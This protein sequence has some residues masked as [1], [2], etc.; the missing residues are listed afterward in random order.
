MTNLVLSASSKIP[1]LYEK[2]QTAIAACHSFDE[3]KAIADQAAAI[4]AYHKQIKDDVAMRQFL[5]IVAT[6]RRDF[7]SV[8]YAGLRDVRGLCPQGQSDNP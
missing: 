2:M 8:C 1:R 3:V 7:Q 5:D 6:S 4:A